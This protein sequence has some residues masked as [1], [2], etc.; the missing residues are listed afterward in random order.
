[1]FSQL[2][3]AQMQRVASVPMSD[4]DLFG[5][6][7]SFHGRL[8]DMV[9]INLEL[10]C[11]GQHCDGKL[12]YIRSGLLFRLSGTA[13][14]HQLELREIDHNGAV[15]G[16]L[17]IQKEGNGL[18]GR[19][20]NASHSYG[21]NIHFEPVKA[22]P[23]NPRFCGDNKWLHQLKGS[24]EGRAVEL[25]LHKHS[26][27]QLQGVI[28]THSQTFEVKG[29]LR[30]KGELDLSFPKDIMGEDLDYNKITLSGEGIKFHLP[31]ENQITLLSLV[32]SQPL[33]CMEYMDYVR[34]IEITYPK[35]PNIA[36]NRTIERL[37]EN[38]VGQVLKQTEIGANGTGALTPDLRA[39]AVARSWSIIEHYSD[40]LLSGIQLFSSSFSPVEA[41]N[42]NYD[43]VSGEPLALSDL[44]RKGFNFRT[45]LKHH[46]KQQLYKGAL[47]EKDQYYKEWISSQ[48]FDLFTLRK[49]GLRL[50]SFYHP[51]YGRQVVY[52]PRDE[53]QP[54]LRKN[55]VFKYFPG[56]E[57]QAAELPS[58]GEF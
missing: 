25:I 48:D 43:L 24:H 19:W 42:I 7:G 18:L 2:S 58:K 35:T 22:F 33:G 9:D 55:N 12:Q 34:N 14:G 11:S 38:W 46:I 10:D 15:S 28:S 26:D 51:V 31:K 30:Q 5:L 17:E 37:A 3:A 40:Q 54:Y 36:V 44:F 50:H 6:T 41:V 4:S 20:Y 56:T 1:M 27:N 53:L 8:N 21:G 39:S 45:V 49:D 29:S 47:W 13:S 57:N 52:I 16:F 32:N 23:E